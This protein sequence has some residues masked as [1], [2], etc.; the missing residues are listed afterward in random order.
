MNG[1]AI[2]LDSA[3]AIGTLIL[4]Y[5]TYQSVRQ[6]KNVAEDARQSI[7]LTRNIEK[8]K[9]KPYC[10]INPIPGRLGEAVCGTCPQAFLEDS[11]T[12]PTL[13]C[14]IKN[15]A[16]VRRRVSDPPGRN[17]V[18][19]NGLHGVRRLTLTRRMFCQMT[20]S[21]EFARAKRAHCV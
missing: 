8:A 7:N 17:G 15:D 21:G 12:G 3:T 14:I 16:P 1:I 13:S 2:I 9:I 19:K 6:S 5:F 4:A 20:R 11:R 10:P 18:L